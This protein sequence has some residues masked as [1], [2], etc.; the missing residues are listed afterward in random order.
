MV[1][2]GRLVSFQIEDDNNENGK[3]VVINKKTE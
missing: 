2:M 3:S 1:G